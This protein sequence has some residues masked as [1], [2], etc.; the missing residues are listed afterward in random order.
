MIKCSLWTRVRQSLDLKHHGG[1]GHVGHEC[2]NGSTA[3]HEHGGDEG[4]GWQQMGALAKGMW[5]NAF[6]SVGGNGGNGGN[7]DGRTPDNE[8]NMDTTTANKPASAPTPSK[9]VLP[10]QTDVYD[11]D[12]VSLK[13]CLRWFTRVEKLGAKAYK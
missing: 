8:R 3:V 10:Q 2:G 1:Y 7:G 4:V 13:Q 12:S 11:A 9:S 5:E 6:N